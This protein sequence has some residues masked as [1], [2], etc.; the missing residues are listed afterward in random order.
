MSTS[1]LTVVPTGF[2]AA[3]GTIAALP[4]SVVFQITYD[5]LDA[6]FD[7]AAAPR[8]DA[9]AD[10]LADASVA[11]DK[12]QSAINAITHIFRCAAIDIV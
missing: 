7:K 4:E 12:V 8:A 10:L 11:A 1:F 5:S 3:I 9:Y 6:L 2:H